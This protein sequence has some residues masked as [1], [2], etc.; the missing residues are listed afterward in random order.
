M[1]VC[2]TQ[3]LGESP[4]R[5]HRRALIHQ[6]IEAVLS[7][8]AASAHLCL[9]RRKPAGELG[10]PLTGNAMLTIQSVTKDPSIL[11]PDHATSTVSPS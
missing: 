4:D 6:L 11:Q 2:L 5:T 7:C 9:H 1:L 8:G 3:A 10:K